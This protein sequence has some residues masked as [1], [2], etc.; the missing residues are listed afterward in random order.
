MKKHLIYQ[1]TFLLLG[2]VSALSIYAQAPEKFIFQAE[3]RDS[4]GKPITK[5]T[6]LSVKIIILQGSPNGDIVWEGNHEVTTD[7]YGLFTLVIGE[8][9]STYSFSAIDWDNYNQFLNVQVNDGEV[10]VDMGTTQFLSVPYA[11][12][13]NRA[14]SVIT[15]TELDPVYST[16]QAANITAADITNLDNLSGVNSGDQDLSNV[17]LKSNVLELDNTTAFTPDA[18]YEPATKKYV[19]DNAGGGGATT[20]SIG[21][22]A[23][24][25]I[26]FWVDETGQHGLVCAKQD[27]GGFMEWQLPGDQRVT[28]SYGNG[29]FSGETNTILILSALAEYH[30]VPIYAALACFTL[31]I[32]ENEKT[33]GDWYLPSSGELNLMYQ[34]KA[35]IDATA[36]ANGGSAF[37]SLSSGYY[38]SSNEMDPFLAYC[39]SFVNGLIIA[40]VKQ[41]LYNV[42]A[43]RRF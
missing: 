17:A 12:H 39:Q 30:P 34:N 31:Q 22:F 28:M 8:G 2:F 35:I 43:V 42:R 13:A 29:P 41:N 26:V 38:W 6:E 9:T 24:G 10:W 25:G 40:E 4:K 15:F 20:Y 14:D 21:N 11:L 18:D 37:S 36:T 16:S 1:L 33:Y 27:Q 3:A 19:D 5:A 7:D 23:Q 32:T